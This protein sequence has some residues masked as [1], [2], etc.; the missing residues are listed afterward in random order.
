MSRDFAGYADQYPD[1]RW[2]N[3]AQLAVSV[4]LNIEEGAELALSAGDERNEAMHEVT[5]EV[6]GAPD[7]R[8][9][10]ALGIPCRHGT[11]R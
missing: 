3:G 10:L 8:P 7:L 5:H 4:V 11:R 6:Q 2:P 9:R 1:V